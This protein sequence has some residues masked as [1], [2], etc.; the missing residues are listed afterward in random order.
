MR[1]APAAVFWAYCDTDP[2]F[3]YLP[4][5]FCGLQELPFKQRQPFRGNSCAVF[6]TASQLEVLH[7]GVAAGAP[8]QQ[9]STKV[10][11]AAP[12]S[13]ATSSRPWRCQP[14]R[15]ISLPLSFCVLLRLQNRPVSCICL[16]RRK[17][18]SPA[19]SVRQAGP[20]QVGTGPDK[21]GL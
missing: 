8:S 20:S 15:T 6:R 12:A 19:L 3:P 5:A 13:A 11:Y 1:D 18:E 9:L 17:Q 16:R 2:Q 21:A 7:A 10:T 4:S 14:V